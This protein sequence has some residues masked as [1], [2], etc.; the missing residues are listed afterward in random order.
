MRDSLLLFYLPSRVQIC[1][2]FKPKTNSYL[3]T[4]T[5]DID[6]VVLDFDSRNDAQAENSKLLSTQGTNEAKMALLIFR[7]WP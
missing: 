6:K 4:K 2:T 3:I 7:I 5:I 1:L